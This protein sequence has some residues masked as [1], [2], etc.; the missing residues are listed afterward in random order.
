MPQQAAGNRFGAVHIIESLSQGD[1]RTD[2]RLFDE[3]Q[4]LGFYAAENGD[5][6][7]HLRSL[8]LPDAPFA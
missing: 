4:P 5:A 2:E 1:L 3:L 8:L 7:E 6:R